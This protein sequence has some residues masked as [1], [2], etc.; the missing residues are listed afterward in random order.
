VSFLNTLSN[1]E[2]PT[3]TIN[4]KKAIS[5]AA[6]LFPVPIRAP[7]PAKTQI[8]AAEVTP[9][10]SPPLVKIIPAPKNP[11]PEIICPRT[12]DGLLSPT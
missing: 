2:T 1:A 12:R 3:K 9:C 11:T 7:S 6:I 8:I 4:T 5:N 10:T